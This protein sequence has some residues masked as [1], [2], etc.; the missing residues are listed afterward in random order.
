VAGGVCLQHICVSSLILDALLAHLPGTG[1]PALQEQ[2][3][4]ELNVRK[5]SRS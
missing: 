1:A 2:W 5:G 3:S 4:K